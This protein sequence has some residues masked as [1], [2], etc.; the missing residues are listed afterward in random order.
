MPPQQP[1]QQQQAPRLPEGISLADADKP[2]FA[3]HGAILA[4]LNN[5]AG[6]APTVPPRV[7]DIETC[8]HTRKETIGILETLVKGGKKIGEVTKSALR[9]PFFLMSRC[10][11]LVDV[12]I[13]PNKQPMCDCQGEPKPMSLVRLGGGADSARAKASAAKT[14]HAAQGKETA[15]AA[16]LAL[17]RLP[18][19]QLRA[20]KTKSKRQR[21]AAQKKLEKAV[22]EMSESLHTTAAELGAAGDAVAAGPADAQGA[23]VAPEPETMYGSDRAKIRLVWK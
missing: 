6:A 2:L 3:D 10:Q 4:T 1:P 17:S 14:R 12:G 23:A 20:S 18:A 11:L 7:L 13:I 8:G 15:K 9:T 21:E 16:Q 5:E 22:M 19:L